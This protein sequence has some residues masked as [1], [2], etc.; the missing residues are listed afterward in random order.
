MTADATDYTGC[1]NHSGLA[2]M[3]GFVVF[4]IAEYLSHTNG[5]TYTQ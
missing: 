2:W 5:L 4:G 3:D 1:I